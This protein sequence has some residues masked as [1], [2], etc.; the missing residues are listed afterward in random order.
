MAVSLLPGVAFAAGP[1]T[2]AAGSAVAVT[3]TTVVTFTPS[4]NGF[5]DATVL[6][7]TTFAITATANITIPSGVTYAAGST[8]LGA[9]CGT[10]GGC[11]ALYTGDYTVTATNTVQAA[12]GQQTAT[13]HLVIKAGAATKFVVSG[14]AGG[15][16]ATPLPLHRDDTGVVTAEDA[17]S[18]VAIS[19]TGSVVFYSTDSGTGATVTPLNHVFTNVDAG[20]FHVL[21][22]WVTVGSQSFTATE[23]TPSPITGTQSGIVV[24]GAATYATF[25]PIGP[26]RV[27]DSRIGLGRSGAFAANTPT[28]FQITGVGAVP[29]E[30]NGNIVAVTGNLTVAAPSAG[31]AVALG[32]TAAAASSGTSMINFLAGQTVSNGVTVQVSSTGAL[33]ADF[34]TSTPGAST[35]L[36]FDVTG[37]FYALDAVTGIPVANTSLFTP[38]GPQRQIDTRSGVGTI[39][40]A[41]AVTSTMVANQPMCFTLNL[42]AGATAVVGNV[43][44]TGATNGWAVN[45]GPV[46]SASPSTST[47]NFTG[48]QTVANSVTVALALNNVMC[49][50]FISTAGNTTDLVFDVTGFYALNGQDFFTPVAPT[51]LVDTRQT[52]GTMLSGVLSANLPR[53]FQ[54]AS[55]T[56]PTKVTTVVAQG[57]V[58]ISGNLTFTNE[59]SGWAGYVGP[60]PLVGPATSSINFSANQV[61]SNGITVPLGAGYLYPTYISSAGNTADMVLDVTGFFTPAVI[62]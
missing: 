60:A 50:T 9:T 37:I 61:I 52:S 18:N 30:K 29:A 47:I 55:S 53:I 46:A 7:D 13:A 16:L 27:L 28:S 4:V 51:R 39:A 42:P 34:V 8:V 19:Y 54:V 62:N 43:T 26:I 45:L 57:A 1:L 33:F 10:N 17:Q 44:V 58:A 15:T 59:T 35:N 3:P 24:G 2:L 38:F 32:K 48:G 14:F 21:A 40:L 56:A 49:A 12:T 25:A 20:V 22:T 6:P 31:Y 11:Q 23:V 5:T 36:V 41:P